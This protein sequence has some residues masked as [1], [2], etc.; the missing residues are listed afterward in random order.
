MVVIILQL[1]Q[2]WFLSFQHLHCGYKNWHNI[3]IPYNFSHIDTK[4]SRYEIVMPVRQWEL[5][6]CKCGKTWY[7]LWFSLCHRYT[8]VTQLIETTGKLQCKIEQ[9]WRDVE[10]YMNEDPWTV[11]SQSEATY[12]SQDL[13][14]QL[15]STYC[16]WSPINLFNFWTSA[17]SSVT[18]PWPWTATLPLPHPSSILS[19]FPILR[20]PCTASSATVSK[21]ESLGFL[22]GQ[23]TALLA[24]NLSDALKD[25]VDTE[26]TWKYEYDSVE[27]AK[28]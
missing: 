27:D 20:S 1:I 26:D 10:Q 12:V 28:T 21:W 24:L 13:K 22:V 3:I 8:C 5:V 14:W 17:S 2:L 4:A 6:Q 16:Q 11:A 9:K 7:F 15:K 23:S 19:F 18:Y 25:S